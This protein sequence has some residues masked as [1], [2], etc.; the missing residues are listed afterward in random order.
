MPTTTYDP[1]YTFPFFDQ[2]HIPTVNPE[3][4]FPTPQLGDPSLSSTPNPAFF[5]MF[6]P[7]MPYNPNLVL[8]LM[9]SM[10]QPQSTQQQQ[11][12]VDQTFIGHLSHS[13]PTH[14][15]P[16]HSQPTHQPTANTQT[17]G[18]PTRSTIQNDVSTT[19]KMLLEP[20]GDM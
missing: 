16:S 18:R 6:G 8:S 14:G 20:E 4:T 13:Q 11:M 2:H 3:T 5:Q 19:N 12:Q 15:Q 7:Y 17:E 1:W 10:Q 9:G